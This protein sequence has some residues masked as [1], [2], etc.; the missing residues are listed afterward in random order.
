METM[1]RKTSNSGICS[2][3]FENRVRSP[4]SC[5][6]GVEGGYDFIDVGSEARAC[7]GVVEQVQGLFGES[8]GCGEVLNELTNHMR[9]RFCWQAGIRGRVLYIV[10]EDIDDAQAVDIDETPAMPLGTVAVSPG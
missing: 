1:E 3:R 10:V 4:A 5:A 6:L 9:R 7:G 8:L 2:K